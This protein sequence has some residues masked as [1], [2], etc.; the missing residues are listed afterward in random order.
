VSDGIIRIVKHIVGPLSRSFGKALSLYYLPPR[1]AA[2]AAGAQ[3]VLE[4]SCFSSGKR[5]EDFLEL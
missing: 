4:D 1:C 3:R 5:G 2:G